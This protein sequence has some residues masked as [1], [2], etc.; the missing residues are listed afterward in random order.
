MK[1]FKSL[2]AMTKTQ[3]AAFT[4]VAAS[5]V[6]PMS[7]AAAGDVDFSAMIG[8]VVATGCV[9]AI[10]AMGVVKIAPNFAKWAVNKVASFF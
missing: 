9:A 7:F 2:F 4:A 8:G 1:Q 6:A 10:V 3:A 5:V